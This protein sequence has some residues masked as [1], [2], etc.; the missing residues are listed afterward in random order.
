MNMDELE[1]LDD[2]MQVDGDGQ[3]DEGQD[4]D[5]EFFDQ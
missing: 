5:N 4:S 2:S 3:G 1:P